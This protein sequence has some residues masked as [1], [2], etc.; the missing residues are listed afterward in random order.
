MPGKQANTDIRCRVESCAFH[1]GEQDYCSLSAIQ[2][3]PCP[4][5][6]SGK[7]ESESCCGSYRRR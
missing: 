7:A 3:E 4:N 2:V 1:L 6:S 5:C